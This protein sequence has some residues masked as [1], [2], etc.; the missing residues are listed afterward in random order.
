MVSVFNF[1]NYRTYL[2]AYYNEKKL[3]GNG[4]SYKTLS[5]R[6]G[7]KDKS[8]LYGVM[9]NKK[10]LSKSSIFKI[11]QALKHNRHEAD[12]FENLVGFNQAKDIKEQNYCFKRMQQVK[13][14]GKGFV[15]AKQL[16]GDQYDYLSNWYNTV[17]HTHITLFGFDGDYKY[18]AKAVHPAILPKQAKK[19]VELLQRLRL[20]TKSADGIWKVVD[21]A[22]ATP[23]EVSSLAIRN[24]HAQMA[25]LGLN[26]LK[27]LPKEKRFLTGLTLGI[28]KETYD[29]ICC[30]VEKFGSELLE[31]AVKDDKADK[32]YHMNIQLFPVSQIRGNAR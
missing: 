29:T 22:L 15:G 27:D 7:F 9:K 8:F 19:S 28:S 12:Y 5:D 32:V 13:G 24:F 1:T 18:L 26:A 30:K 16:R 31:M 17:I 3:E 4:S 11:S 2:Q 6:I 10:N 14:L 20:I 23:R 25:E 21:K